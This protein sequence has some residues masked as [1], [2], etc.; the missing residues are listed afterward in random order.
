MDGLRVHKVCQRCLPPPS[1]IVENQAEDEDLS[2]KSACGPWASAAP[3]LR[4]HETK[5]NTCGCVR[6]GTNNQQMDFGVP[7][8]ASKQDEPPM[9]CSQLPMDNTRHVSVM[10]IL[11]IGDW[12]SRSRHVR[13]TKC[14]ESPADVVSFPSRFAFRLRV[15]PANSL[16]R[17]RT[18][19]APLHL[20]G[21]RTPAKTYLLPG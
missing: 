9:L 6:T 5:N 3:P 21:I 4:P 13:E 18:V 20:A 15:S 8:L 14:E 10:G 7:C 19:W 12:K 17:V 16:E 2:D 11:D 1:R